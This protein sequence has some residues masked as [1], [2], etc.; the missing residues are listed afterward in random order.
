MT[1]HH[2]EADIQIGI[3]WEQA[4]QLAFS[5]ILRYSKLFAGRQCMN[6]RGPYASFARSV[7]KE[8]DKAA[9]IPSY[10]AHSARLG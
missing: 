4:V 10:M 1:F 6:A 8:M 9:A 7:S 5:G 2:G 3:I